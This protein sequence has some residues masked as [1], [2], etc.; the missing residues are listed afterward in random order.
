[1]QLIVEAL[2]S[3]DLDHALAQRLLC[4]ESWQLPLQGDG[5]SRF[6]YVEAGTVEYGGPQPAGPGDFLLFGPQQEG[7]LQGAAGAVL[8]YGRFF[9]RTPWL[10]PALL[11]TQP[12]GILPVLELLVEECARGAVGAELV[13]QQLLRVVLICAIREY[14]AH[15]EDH[16]WMGVLADVRIGPSIRRLQARMDQRWTVASL[17]AEAGMSRSVYA[18]RFKDL[19][20]HGPLEFLTQQRM[21]RATELIRERRKLSDV[22]HSIGYTSDGAFH[23]AFRRVIGVSPGEF[24]RQSA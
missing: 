4:D 10:L 6:V 23:R 18:Q 13:A 8:I 24:R 22:A 1:V 9:S 5:E 20:G 12:S 3:M 16:Q 11:H 2:A 7:L 14:A 15:G 19:T 21:H 17:A